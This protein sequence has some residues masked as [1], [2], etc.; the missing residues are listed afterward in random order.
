MVH[1]VTTLQGVLLTENSAREFYSVYG[2]K[3]L[4]YVLLCVR[5]SYTCQHHSPEHPEESLTGRELVY[6]ENG[7]TDWGTLNQNHQFPS[8]EVTALPKGCANCATP[9]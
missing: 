3:L 5:F 2:S 9:K 6:L 7:H 8:S 4:I 1:M